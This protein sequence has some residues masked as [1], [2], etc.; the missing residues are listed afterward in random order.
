[1]PDEF[2]VFLSHNSRDKPAV[3]E[4]AARLRDRGLR[5]W[6]DKDELQPGLPWQEGLEAGVQTS[7]SVAVFV[8]KE[9][10]GA[11]QEPEMRAFF[12]RSRREE[13]PVIPV[14][15]PGC[16]GFPRLTLFLQGLTWVDLRQGLTDDGLARL[17]WGITG[18]KGTRGSSERPGRFNLPKTP[19]DRW[20]WGIALSLLGVL[21]TLVAWLWPRSPEPPPLPVRPAIY[22]VRVQVLDPQGLRVAGST[23]LASAGNEPQRTPDGWWEVEIPAAKVPAG[24]QITLWAEHPEW[25][26]NRKDLRLGADPNVQV[27]IRLKEPESWLRGRV[28]DESGR[29]L[30]GVSVSIQEGPPETRSQVPK[31]ALRSS[32]RSRPRRE[33]EYRPSRRAWLRQPHSASRTTTPARSSWGNNET[34][35]VQALRFAADGHAPLCGRR[36]NADPA[37]GARS[38]GASTPWPPFRVPGQ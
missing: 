17:V 33:F 13:I 15:L 12:A 6:L 34:K 32:Y 26:G 23:V 38:R 1:M 18:T 37:G 20:S 16:P 11:W 19:R 4:I 21:L 3:E 24:G 27:E 14:L 31:A 8:G 7:R 35:A 30:G 22:A 28:V 36:R 25:G 10:M 5:V 2:D 29:G 9:G